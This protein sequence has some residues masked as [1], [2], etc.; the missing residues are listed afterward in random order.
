MVLLHCVRAE[1]TRVLKIGILLDRILES[2][3]IIWLPLDPRANL[4][5]EGDGGD[6][7]RWPI[8]MTMR[9]E[10]SCLA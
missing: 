9:P 6:P 3:F 4:S 8:K 2:Q 10:E 5:S 1:G 7:G